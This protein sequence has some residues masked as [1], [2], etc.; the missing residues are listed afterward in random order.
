MSQS[1]HQHERGSNAIPIDARGNIALPRGVTLTSYLDDNVAELGDAVAYRYLDFERDGQPVEL[2]WNRLRGRLRA[3]GARVQQVAARGERV[4]LWLRRE[5][6]TWWASSQRFR[7]ARSPC[8][9]SRRNCP[10]TLHVS[11]RCC[12]THGPPWC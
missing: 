7:P 8:H 11:S 3:V 4:R 10:G 9:C 2:T 6:T 12:Q 1:G 5:L